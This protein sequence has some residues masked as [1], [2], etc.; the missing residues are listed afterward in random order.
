MDDEHHILS[1][2]AYSPSPPSAAQ[3]PRSDDSGVPDVWTAEREQAAQETYD[4][5]VADKYIYDLMR[6]FAS[7]HRALAMYDCATCL[8]ELEKIPAVHQL[9]PWVL[10]MTGRAHFERADYM[11]AE[12]A[13]DAARK[14]EP[15]RLWDME[16]YSTLLWHLQKNVQLSYLA[17]ELLNINP[18]SPQAWI[19]VGN[20]FSLQKERSQAL[21]CFRRASQLDPACA[22]AYTLSGH[23]YMDDDLEKSVS[24]FQSALRVDPRHYNAWYGLGTCYLR[25]SRLRL[26]E[27]HY[28]R[29]TLIHPNNAVLLG[30]V[31]MAVERRGDRDG[32]FAL[33]DEAVRLAPEN[34]LVRYRRAKILISMRRFEEAAS[35]LERLRD[36]SPEESNVVFQLARV[37]RL[38]GNETKATQTLAVARDMS[39][40]SLSKIKK[41]L[42]SKE[43]SDEMDE[44]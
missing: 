13:F 14:E 34:A 40:K 38:M 6:L 8:E 44:G 20:C 4:I 7:A 36:V 2:P 41:L 5:A 25:M 21:T 15:Y 17:Q 11:K 19:A 27:Y 3:S 10:A 24:F 35:D 32:A 1:D 16:V 26:A 22:Y 43:A 12:R 30:C 33:Y 18:R 39:P 23:E 9:S 29:A 42:E 37:Y 28:R 31:G